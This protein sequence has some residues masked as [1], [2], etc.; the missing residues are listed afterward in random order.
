MGVGDLLAAALVGLLARELKLDGARGAL[1][2]HVGRA[3]TCA[4]ARRTVAA[5]GARTPRGPA[6]EGVVRAPRPAGAG[7]ARRGRVGVLRGEAARAHGVVAGLLV[8]V[9]ERLVCLGQLLE[10]LLG[11]R[12]LADVG[13]H[14]AGLGAE[15]LL[16]VV[17]GGVLGDAENLV[18]ILMRGCGQEYL[19]PRIAGEKLLSV[20]ILPACGANH[21][22]PRYFPTSLKV[23]YGDRQPG[24]RRGLWQER[25]W[26]AEYDEKAMGGGSAGA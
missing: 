22:K 5:E 24:K 23:G 14:G 2:A 13:V 12:L 17:D 10:A 21:I 16:D 26:D 19:T 1:T 7:R 6:A 9:R 8:G 4:G 3:L 20:G 25:R 15:G 11:A 18:V